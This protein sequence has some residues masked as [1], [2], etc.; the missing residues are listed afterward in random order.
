MALNTCPLKVIGNSFNPGAIELKPPSFYS[1][2]PSI[3]NDVSY[4]AKI[5]SQGK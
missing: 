2:C 1:G 5:S 3:S 4:E